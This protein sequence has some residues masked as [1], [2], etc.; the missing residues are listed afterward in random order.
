MTLPLLLL[1]A[2][3]MPAQAGKSYCCVDANGRQA[4]GDILPQQCYGRAYREVGERG[5]TLRQVEA[6]LTGE[7]K[8]QRE[9]ELA[10]KKEIERIAQEEK[11][12]NQALLNTFGSERDIDAMRDYKLTDMDKALKEIQGKLDTVL[13]RKQKLDGEMEFYKKKAVPPELKEQIRVND[14]EIKAH[15]AALE[16]KKQEMEAVRTKFEADK[17][18][19]RELT[20]GKAT[21]T[22]VVPSSTGAA[23]SRPR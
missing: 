19:F 2:L 17:K 3:P 4:C 23:S 13:K 22:T 5:N 10:K 8:T 14:V 12:R 9:A 15:S 16:A 20:G 21:T 1:A 11:R 7:Q 18:R 6:P